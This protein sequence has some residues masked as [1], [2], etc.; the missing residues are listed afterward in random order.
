MFET[1]WIPLEKTYFEAYD[2]QGTADLVLE[3]IPWDLSCSQK[4]E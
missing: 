3:S 4:E 2:I 1:R